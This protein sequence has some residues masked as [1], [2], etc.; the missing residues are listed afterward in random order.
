MGQRP[1][2]KKRL[3][4]QKTTACMQRKVRG[5]YAIK[6]L[7]ETDEA[8]KLTSVETKSPIGPMK[9]QLKNNLTYGMRTIARISSRASKYSTNNIAVT[10][11]ADTIEMAS[12]PTIS[13]I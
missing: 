13:K 6:D 4:K 12:Q 10:N 5:E 8:P 1:S 2:Q 11:L 9:S 7:K 3:A